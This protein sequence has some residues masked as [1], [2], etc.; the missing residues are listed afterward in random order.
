MANKTKLPKKE[1]AAAKTAK[2]VAPTTE[3]GFVVVYNGEQ[4]KMRQR[5]YGGFKKLLAAAIKLQDK[6]RNFSWEYYDMLPK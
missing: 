1:S 6:D 2:V 3:A 5:D 4:I